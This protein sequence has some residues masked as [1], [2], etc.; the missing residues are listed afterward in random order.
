MTVGL[1]TTAIF[2]DLS[3]Y[4]FG[5]VK[6]MSTLSQKSETVT[7]NGETTTK[8]GDCRTFLRQCGQAFRDKASINTWRYAAPCRPVIDCTMNDLEWLFHVK[9]RFRS[10]TPSRAYLCVS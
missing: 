4:F 5:T 3:G 10:A 8:F 2:G 7:E 6:P 9:M 1:S